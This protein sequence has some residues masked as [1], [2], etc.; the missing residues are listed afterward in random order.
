MGFTVDYKKLRFNNLTSPQF[1]HLFFI[2]FWPIYLAIFFAT[3]KF[4]VPQYDIYSPIDDFIPFCEFFVIPYF[5]WYGLLAFASLYTLFFD[6]PAFKRF[7]KFLCVT[8]IITFLIHII[9]PNM[10]SLRPVEFARDNIFVDMMRGIYNADTNTNVCPSIHVVFSMGITFSLWNSKHFSSAFWRCINVIITISICLS[11]VFLKQ[12][13]VIDIF[14][15]V[16]LSAA[17]YPFIFLDFKKSD[18]S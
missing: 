17:V 3:E 14:V 9:F 15:G 6:V 1:R 12:H 10:Q 18:K 5:L 8:S 2:L 16:L 7:Y 11:T 4:I 13:S